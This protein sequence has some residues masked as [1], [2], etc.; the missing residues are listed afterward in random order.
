MMLELRRSLFFI[1]SRLLFVVYSVDDL[2]RQLDVAARAA[3]TRRQREAAH[4]ENLPDARERA[5]VRA[6]E[7]VDRLAV[8]ADGDDAAPAVSL[9]AQAHLAPRR[10]RVLRLVDEEDRDR[11]LGVGIQSDTVGERHVKHVGA[12]EQG[13]LLPPAAGGHEVRP[14]PP[15]GRPRRL[16]ARL[17]D[18]DGE[19]DAPLQ[20]GCACRPPRLQPVSDRAWEARAP[21]LEALAVGR[22]RLGD[23]TEPLRV[24]GEALHADAPNFGGG[25][26]L[27]DEAAEH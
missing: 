4:C 27:V 10:V 26:E 1:S 13:E 25:H 23:F 12:V 19:L 17:Q 11:L 6:E 14:T 15:V 24:A 5:G 9:E 3:I 7:R 8:V 2:V 21:L 22:T 20:Q 18:L 16:A